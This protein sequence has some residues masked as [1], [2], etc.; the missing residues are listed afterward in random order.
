LSVAVV[1][2]AVAHLGARL[3]VALTREN[4]IDA[5]P[6]AR[7]T[8][9]LAHAIGRSVALGVDHTGRVVFGD[10]GQLVDLPIAVVVEPVTDFRRAAVG[11]LAHDGAGFGV[12]HEHPTALAA[13][14]VA[15]GTDAGQ[16]LGEVAGAIDVQAV[17][18]R[19]RRPR[20]LIVADLTLST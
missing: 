5:F 11:G 10:V 8:G 13:V 2:L 15:G 3:H 19:V 20:T 7:L 4:A 14:G 18:G 17:A 16:V 9:A 1:V 12:A 6:D